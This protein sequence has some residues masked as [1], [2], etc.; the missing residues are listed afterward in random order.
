[1]KAL[2]LRV[3]VQAVL[4]AA[5]F[6]P[7]HLLAMIVEIAVRYPERSEGVDTLPEVIFVWILF[8]PMMA[9]GMVHGLVAAL[10]PSGWSHWTRLVATIALSPIVPA[11]VIIGGI[12]GDSML[13]VFWMSTAIAT[14]CYGL[15]SAHWAGRWATDAIRADK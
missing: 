9:A 14:V 15:A 7:T 11:T 12:Q 8:L 1:M 2:W 13:R 5:I 4:V 3:L 10:I 6:I